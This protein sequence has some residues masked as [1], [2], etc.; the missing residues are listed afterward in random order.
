MV[1]VQEKFSGKCHIFATALAPS[2]LDKG[3]SA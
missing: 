2:I 1:D 3:L